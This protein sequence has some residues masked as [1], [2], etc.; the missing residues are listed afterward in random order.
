MTDCCDRSEVQTRI[1]LGVICSLQRF[2][3][4]LD[5]RNFGTP[6]HMSIFSE[7]AAHI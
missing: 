2:D 6:K 3:W 7:Q 5:D 1:L 4:Y